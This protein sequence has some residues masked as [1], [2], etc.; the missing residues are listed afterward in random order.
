[1]SGKNEMNKKAPPKGRFNLT[2]SL[3]A[4]VYSIKK[5]SRLIEELF[6]RAVLKKPREK[7]GKAFV[8]IELSGGFVDVEGAD[9]IQLAALVVRTETQVTFINDPLRTSGGSAFFHLFT[10]LFI[11]NVPRFRQR[12]GAAPIA[13]LN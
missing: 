8:G 6:N 2:G 3:N 10:H 12:V 13:L 1:M 5:S 7:F 4:A 11:Q 9:R